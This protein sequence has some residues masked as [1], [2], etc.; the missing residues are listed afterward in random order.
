MRIRPVKLHWSLTRIIRT[1]TIIYI[2]YCSTK[3]LV[4]FQSRL[5]V[6]VQVNFS[7]QFYV[8]I[9]AK[10][11]IHAFIHLSLVPLWLSCGGEK[12]GESK[13]FLQF[14]WY[15]DMG[16]NYTSQSRS[17]FDWYIPH[18]KNYL[19]PLLF[20]KTLGFF[21]SRLNEKVQV[22]FSPQIYVHINAK[23]FIHAFMHLCLVRLWL[24]MWWRKNA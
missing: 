2:L 5:N 14:L 15:V 22:Y 17:E 7:P 11:F 6:E 16:E 19:H 12:T 24:I 23:I 4:L 10:L 9:N 21:Q 8:H 18:L 1:Y 13:S 20:Y 3:P